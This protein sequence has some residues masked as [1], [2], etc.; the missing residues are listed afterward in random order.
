MEGVTREVILVFLRWRGGGSRAVLARPQSR[1]TKDVRAD[2]ARL[3]R[4]EQFLNHK[5]YKKVT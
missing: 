1:R 4:A 3:A 5:K 2:H